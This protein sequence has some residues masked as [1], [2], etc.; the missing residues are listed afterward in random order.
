MKIVNLRLRLV[1]W[2]V[3]LETLLL[4]V[5]A[6]VF[7]AVLQNAQNQQIEETLR[8]SAAQLNAVVDI[9]SGHYRIST[10]ETADMRARGVMAWILSPDGQLGLTIGNAENYPVPANL[11]L[12]GQTADHFLKEEEIIRLWVSPLTEGAN[13]F[14]TLVVALPLRSSQ[15]FLRQIYLGLA[16]AIPLVV[17]LSA[18]GGLFLARRALQPVATITHTARTISAADLSQRIALDLPDDEIGQLAATFNAMLERLDGAFQRERQFTS[19]VS[20]ELRTPLGFIKTQLSLARS[21]PRNAAALLEMMAGMEGDVDRMTRLVEQM[22]SLARVEQRGLE[23][24]VPVDLGALL[25]DLHQHFQPKGGQ[26]D[27]ELSL[28]LPPQVELTVNGDQA[29]LRQVF[30]NLVENAFKYTPRG[31]Q[32]NLEVVRRWD[33][34]EVKVTNFGMVIPPEDIPHLFE[35]FYRVESSRSRETGGAGLGLAISQEI[36]RRHG[37]TIEVQSDADRGTLFCVRLPGQHP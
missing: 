32:I 19:D 36:V 3:A 8:L 30:T 1:L 22:L 27:I 4:I 5:F 31:G 29:G 26:D 24:F 13:E 33:Q 23:S 37:G 25:G 2:S 21:R 28:G 34:I 10:A 6:A 7:V 12:P 20:H 18:A 11:P 9:Q 14:G 15:T 35:R 17:L 16:V